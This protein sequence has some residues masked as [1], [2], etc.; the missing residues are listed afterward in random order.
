MLTFTFPSF[1]TE[2]LFLCWVCHRG[3]C[4]QNKTKLQI[5]KP[6]GVTPNIRE[7]ELKSI[8]NWQGALNKKGV[9]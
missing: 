6:K 9:K 1:A 3:V 2:F 7:R 8:V 4:R 5:N